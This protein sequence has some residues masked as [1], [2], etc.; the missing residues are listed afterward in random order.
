M[1][2]VVVYDLEDAVERI[3]GPFYNRHAAVIYAN[4]LD[5]T[6]DYGIFEMER[7]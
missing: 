2:C 6:D 3:V 4:T 1:F 5:S 7:D